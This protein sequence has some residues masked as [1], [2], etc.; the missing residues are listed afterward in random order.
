MP[1]KIVSPHEVLPLR[2]KVL[3]PNL[4]PEDCVYDHDLSPTT[5]HLGYL[6]DDKVCSILTAIREGSPLFLAQHQYRLRG[7]ATDSNSLRRGYGSQLMKTAEAM[8]AEQKG[9]LIWFNARVEAFPFY[10]KMGYGF[11]GEL[12]YIEGIWPHR[13]MFKTML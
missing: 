11:L 4:K 8:I 5:F 2:A 7:I 13:V 6:E 10:Q 3:R 12:F 1:V 9:E